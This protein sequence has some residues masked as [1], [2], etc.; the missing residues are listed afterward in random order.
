MRIKRTFNLL[1]EANEVLDRLL[2]TQ[3]ASTESGALAQILF[4]LDEGM[5]HY[6]DLPALAL[7]ERGELTRSEKRNA[8]QRYREREAAKKAA[9][10][11]P[12]P[13]LMPAA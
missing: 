2:V 12:V 3:S 1:P 11:M 10:G 5:R 9:N 6:L 4:G 13:G 7:Y 8:L